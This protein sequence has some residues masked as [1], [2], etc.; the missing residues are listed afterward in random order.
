MRGPMPNADMRTLVA[1]AIASLAAVGAGAAGLFLSGH[2]AATWLR[3]PL[4][5]VAGALIAAGMIALGRSPK[6]CQWITLATLAGLAATLFSA[7]QSGVHRWV[8]VG[9]LHINIAALALPAAIVCFAGLGV[10]RPVSLAAAGLIGAILLLQPDASQAIAFTIAF[11]FLLVRSDASKLTRAA[12][13]AV[14]AALAVGAWIRRDPLEPVAE[15]EGIFQL[16]GQ[17]SPALAVIAGLGLAGSTLSPLLHV[18]R[19]DRVESNAA[20]ALTMY[21]AVTALAPAMGA[22]PVPM[23]GLGMSFPFGFWLALALLCAAPASSSENGH[24]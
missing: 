17:V 1:F 10:A 18:S 19:V 13:I 4:A 8:D 15:V 2:A 6:L 20:W 22:F 23:V 7:A 9:P 16:L 21:F 3:N 14:S 11:A 5:W 12:G 24:T